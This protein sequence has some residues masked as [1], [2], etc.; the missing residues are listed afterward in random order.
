MRM[1]VDEQE[2]RLLRSVALQNSKA[3]LLARERAE[4]DLLQ[5]KEALEE[6]N[7]R[8]TNI[9]DSI[10]DG[11]VAVDNDWRFTYINRR[12]EEIMQPLGKA[13]Q[14]VLGS[15]LWDAFPD[16]VRTK[17][18]E[19]VRRAA[20]ERV[21]VQFESF[22]QPLN[23][24][25]DIRAYPSPDGLSI[26]YRDI[27]ERKDA[28]KALQR[29]EEQLRALA[30]SIP[31][32]AW[33]AEANG[34]IT[35]YNRKWYDYTGSDFEQM[36][37]WG[38]Q[39][40]HDPK[41]LPLVLERWQASIKSGEPFEMEFPLRGADGVFRW[42]LTRVNPVR[43][44]KDRVIRWFGTNTDVDAVRRAQ[45]ALRESK[46]QLAE[47]NADLDRRVQQRTASLQQAI[48]QLEEFSYSVSHDL[49]APIRAIEAYAHY[50]SADFGPQ[51]PAEAHEFLRKIVRNT[52]RMN[53]LINDV[54]KLSR[55]ARSDIRM[56]PVAV[57]ALI[58]EIIE[59]HPEMQT[60]HAH[61]EVRAD[62]TVLADEVSLS[63]V[64]ANL[65]SN[66]IKFVPP[67]VRP[68]VKISCEQHGERIRLS[69]QDNGIG[70]KPEYQ[71][72]LFGMFQRLHSNPDYD[73]TGVG[74][75]IVKKAV[76]RMGG[77]MGVESDGVSG[78]RFW[79][80]LSNA[81]GNGV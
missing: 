28:E 19:N 50:I 10:T 62:V 38:W 26:Y 64:I 31:Q 16:L 5:T 35:W 61:L 21:T 30:D 63:Q 81:L 8:V 45:E 2:E 70:I 36:H 78:S 77:T 52:A 80:E 11:F 9:L 15:R 67:G 1:N 13:R 4:R 55:I 57:Q 73:G 51:I 71:P 6:S 3:V 18:E 42:F 33:M 59:R 47:A 53:R 46:R 68:V 49:R 66:A 58:E 75:A 76:E 60:P 22:Y 12:G 48:G 32:L 44:G 79:I 23:A 74:L 43:D 27:T 24:W 72:K 54:L 17:C 65:L 7:R 29:S 25:F 14:E 40:V 56:Q 41:M 39:S 37:G 69:V 20:R 34:D